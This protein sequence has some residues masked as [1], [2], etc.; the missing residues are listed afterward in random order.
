MTVPGGK[1]LTLV[2][3]KARDGKQSLHRRNACERIN[4]LCLFP[5]SFTFGP[6]YSFML[7]NKVL[8]TPTCP[9]LP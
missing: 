7:R 2:A 8:P 5:K 6:L 9:P 1:L 3:Y 4:T